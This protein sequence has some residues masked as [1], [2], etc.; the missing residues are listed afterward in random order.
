M[1]FD[2]LGHMHAK[3]NKGAVKKSSRSRSK[4][5]KRSGSPT[6]SKSPSRQKF[7]AWE[8]MMDNVEALAH[9]EVAGGVN[10]AS[11]ERLSHVGGASVDKAS[12]HD[13]FGGHLPMTNRCKQYGESQANCSQAGCQYVVRK[14][15]GSCRNMS[16]KAKSPKK[17]GPSPGSCPPNTHFIRTSKTGKKSCVARVAKSD[18]IGKMFAQIADLTNTINYRVATGLI[19]QELVQRVSKL[20]TLIAKWDRS[21]DPQKDQP[22]MIASM[23]NIR[24]ATNDIKTAARQS[25]GLNFV[26]KRAKKSPAKKS[27]RPK[28]SS[29]NKE[30]ARSSPRSAS[31]RPNRH[32]LSQKRSAPTLIS[33]GKKRKSPKKQSPNKKKKKSPKSPKRSPSNCPKETHFIRT[34]KSGKRSCVKKPVRKKKSVS[35]KRSPKQSPK[36]AASPKRKKVTARKGV[37]RVLATYAP[38]NQY[39]P[40][41]PFAP[42]GVPVQ[43]VHELD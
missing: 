32:K 24:T 33:L 18:D 26:K 27:K 11:A 29:H 5:P 36:R 35:P 30:R 19:D 34:I 4:S 14:G 20:E 42:V 2:L 1:P 22:I 31:K 3:G 10:S 40:N 8:A 16:K 13:L 12:E 15:K 28:S 43:R 23:E 17:K 41:L 39:N 6:R 25:H 9:E 7:K 38:G 37:T 21:S